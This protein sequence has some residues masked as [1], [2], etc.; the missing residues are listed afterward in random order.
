MDNDLP[1]FCA[2][3]DTEKQVVDPVL[4]IVVPVLNEEEN[5][6]ELYGRLIR[7]LISKVKVS[8]ELIFVDDG[9][10]DDSWRVIKQLCQSDQ[11]VRAVKL[12][13]NFGHQK[14]MRAGIDQS[15]GAA[16]ITMDCDLQHPPHLIEVFYNKWRDGYD[17]V[18]SVKISTKRESQF[19]EIST[20]LG[21]RVLNL[22]TNHKFRSGASDFRLIDRKVVKLL[23]QLNEGNLLLRGIVNW[24]GYSKAEVEFDE[25]PRFQGTSSYSYAQLISLVVWGVMSFSKAPMRFAIYVGSIIF[26]LSLIGLGLVAVNSFFLH[27]QLTGWFLVMVLITLFG[28]LN[29][30]FIGIIG[31]FIADMHSDIKIRPPYVIVDQIND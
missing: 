3:E 10:T 16:V 12:S 6:R 5:I 1:D 18:N 20:K 8:Y 21:Y 29:L 13:R 15:N 2:I 25:D 7:V 31:E 19:R 26:F 17:I 30:L 27:V 28:G 22:L 24:T 9:S 4:S 11:S 14:A 23:K